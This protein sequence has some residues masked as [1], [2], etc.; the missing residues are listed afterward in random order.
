MELSKNNLALCEAS[1]PLRFNSIPF[2]PEPSTVKLVAGEVVPI[3][4]FPELSILSL[5][6]PPLL[7]VKLFD[8]SFVISKL[9][10]PPLVSL[11]AVC[12]AV[13]LA[14]LKGTASV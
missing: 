13:D 11:I 4:T 6:E 12:P 2:A 5:S 9:L 14:I 8:P 7:I 10:P 3:P 1:A